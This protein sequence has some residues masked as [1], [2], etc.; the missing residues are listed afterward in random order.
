MTF[1]YRLKAV[2]INVVWS[3]SPKC[4]YVLHLPKWFVFVWNVVVGIMTLFIRIR[5]IKLNT[6]LCTVLISCAIE[7]KTIHK[8]QAWDSNKYLIP[9]VYILV[10]LRSSLR[11]KTFTFYLYLWNSIMA[12]VMILFHIIKSL[13]FWVLHTKLHSKPLSFIFIFIKYISNKTDFH[14]K[15]LMPIQLHKKP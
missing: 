9:G 12:Y 15:S 7:S 11:L 8:C 1:S 5:P 13:I 10:Y 3:T 2:D 14:N 6:E 4:E